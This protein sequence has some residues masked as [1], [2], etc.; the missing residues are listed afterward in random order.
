MNQN[1]LFCIEKNDSDWV[2]VSVSN[3]RDIVL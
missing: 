1:K 2:W 3:Q